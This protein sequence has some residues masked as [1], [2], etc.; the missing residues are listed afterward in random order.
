MRLLLFGT[1]LML[2]HGVANAAI[3]STQTDPN[4]LLSGFADDGI[5]SVGEYAATYSNGGGSGFGGTVGLSSILMDSDITNLYVGF[6]PGGNL[7]NNAVL[8]LDTRAGGFADSQMNDRGD[9][10]RNASSNVTSDV[11]DLFPISPDFA[12]V[13][14]DFGTVVFELN[15][16][17]AGFDETPGNPQNNHLQFQIFEGDQAGSSD[18][19]VREIALPLSLLGNPNQVDFFVAYSS[20]TAFNSNESLPGS[21][22]NSGNNPG[23]DNAANGGGPVTYDNANRFVINPVP[24][25]S[26]IALCGLGL[27]AM[28]LFVKKRK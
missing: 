20:G 28:G 17:G 15:A 21:L 22:I 4:P 3:V 27:A 11:D 23:F 12:V 10:G 13:F 9:G 25:P 14:G 8:F 24:E 5:A 1:A 2:A 26:T 16:F 6:D 19:L 7:D 18:T